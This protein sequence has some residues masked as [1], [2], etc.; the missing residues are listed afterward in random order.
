MHSGGE[1]RQQQGIRLRMRAGFQ[2]GIV[3]SDFAL[4]RQ[5]PRNP[6]DGRMKRECREYEVLKEIGPI[7]AP[8]HMSQ[9]VTQNRFGF[10][11]LRMLSGQQNYRMKEA[12]HE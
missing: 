10:R 9:F 5:S 12:K 8:A 3:T 2:N 4:Q 11:W 6:P 7:I 1:I